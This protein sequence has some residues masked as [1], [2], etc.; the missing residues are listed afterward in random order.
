MAHVKRRSNF[1]G[2]VCTN[3]GFTSNPAIIREE[4][5]FVRI[6]FWTFYGGHPLSLYLFGDERVGLKASSRKR[7][8]SQLFQN[9]G[10]NALGQ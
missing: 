2:K 3:L 9:A 4:V 7:R 1:I 5:V 6:I 8:S 10:D